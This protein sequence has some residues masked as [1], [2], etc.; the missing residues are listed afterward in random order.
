VRDR[1]RNS[2]GWGCDR[3]ALWKKNKKENKKE[4]EKI[5]I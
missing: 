1:G 4:E 2:H 5:E 3:N